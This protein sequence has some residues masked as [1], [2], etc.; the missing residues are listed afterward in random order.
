M[1]ISGIYKIEHVDSGKAYVGSAVNIKRRWGE[2]KARLNSKTHPNPKLQNAW[3]KYGEGSFVFGVVEECEIEVL[4][5]REQK[6]I[7]TLEV[8]TLGYN[9]CEV[10]GSVLGIKRSEETKLRMS[11]A[12]KGRVMSEE[13]RKNI[14]LAQLGKTRGPHTEETKEKIRVANKNYV[15]PPQSEETKKKRS[16]SLK[17]KKRAE[18]SEETR[19]KMSDAGKGKKL[20]EETRQRLSESAKN[21]W[22]K[23]K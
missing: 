2:H 13:H 3:N 22:S 15:K 6:Y 18:F 1:K 10:A 17:G 19:K 20:S 11:E 8:V 5:E 7:D 12:Q 16:E 23:F 21:Y 9:I 14:G 4:I